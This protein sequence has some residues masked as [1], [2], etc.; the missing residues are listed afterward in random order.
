MLALRLLLVLW[1][2][3]RLWLVSASEKRWE[4]EFGNRAIALHDEAQRKPANGRTLTSAVEDAER[5]RRLARLIDHR[6]AG[7]RKW[8][9]RKA[10]AERLA[11]RAKR[12]RKPGWATVALAGLDGAV[13]VS[14]V[15]LLTGFSLPAE[16][17]AVMASVRGWIG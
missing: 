6:D 15:S 14:L 12:L 10:K 8:F 3:L 1:T 11:A 17:A 2:R 7:E 9:R 16:V 5:Q 4:A 13:G